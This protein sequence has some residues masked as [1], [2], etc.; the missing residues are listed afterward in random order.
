LN[1]YYRNIEYSKTDCYSVGG[2]ESVFEKHVERIILGTV[3]LN[4]F[5]IDVG[6]MDYGL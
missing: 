5:K 3:V 4:N 6:A 1:I 2:V